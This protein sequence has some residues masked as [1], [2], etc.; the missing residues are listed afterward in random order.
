[1]SYGFRAFNSSGEKVLDSDSFIYAAGDDISFSQGANNIWTV[2]P[3]Q[4]GDF[5]FFKIDVGRGVVIGAPGIV[6][7]E[8]VN[9]QKQ[10]NT[11]IAP[12]AKATQRYSSQ[13]LPDYGLAVFRSNGEV[14][15]HTGSPL[16]SIKNGGMQNFSSSD[17]GIRNVA[18]PSSVTHVCFQ[19]GFR[20]TQ[21]VSFFQSLWFSPSIYRNSSTNL[22]ISTDAILAF[23]IT[24]QFQR[25]MNVSFLTARITQ[26]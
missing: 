7:L 20:G 6:V 23:A 19:R 13:D 8:T 18:I 1:M 3:G 15:Y 4:T 16:V 5:F 21:Q 2:D 14:S 24:D 22:Q 9:G 26:L 11:N 17:F 25:P 10:V 12:E